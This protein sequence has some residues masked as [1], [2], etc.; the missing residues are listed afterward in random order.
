MTRT[1]LIVTGFIIALGIY[2]LCV[3][4][5][6]GTESS[7]S[8]FMQ[9]SGFHSPFIVFTVGYICG[10]FWGFMPPICSVCKKSME[11]DKLSLK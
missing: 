1:G 3:V 9:E 11:G 2:D 7:V 10:H 5:I 8:R 6:S 4:A